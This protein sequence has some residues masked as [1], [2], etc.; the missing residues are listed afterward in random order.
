M[1]CTGRAGLRA[2]RDNKPEVRTTSAGCARRPR[3]RPRERQK[4]RHPAS[5]LACRAV[6]GRTARGAS[7][8]TRE[9]TTLPTQTGRRLAGTPA[10]NRVRML[11]AL[12]HQ[13]MKRSREKKLR[14]L[15]TWIPESPPQ[16]ILDVGPADEEKSPHD[17]FLEKNHPHPD[18]ITALSI[19][20]LR[21]FRQ[22]YPRT[23]AVTY[24]GTIFPFADGAFD[25]AYSNAVIEH[26]G[27]FP[28]QVLF[29]SEMARVARSLYLTTPAREFPVELHTNLP[30]IH[31]LPTA[32][33]D[34]AV[35]RLHPDWPHGN[36]RLLSRR[37]IN[38]LMKAA[39]VDRF[40]VHV[41][42]L[43][44]FRLHYAIVART[45]TVSHRHDR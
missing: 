16:S 8:D 6:S 1:A 21:S 28:R 22:R 2:G 35:K 40:E 41:Q 27:D 42:R 17:N 29:V 45:P 19:L 23:A 26:V 32:H 25:L 20:P 43:G 3:E 34:R 10:R 5:E 14:H 39:G 13:L 4:P 44:P 12:K 38:D 30:L 15:Q 18:R 9:R 11:L 24:D 37:R 33:F 36:I 7:H 31:W